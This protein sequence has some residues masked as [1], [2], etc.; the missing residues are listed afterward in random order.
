MMG[1][2]WDR[3]PPREEFRIGQAERLAE[4]FRIAAARGRPR[5]LEWVSYA[6]VGEVVW[7]KAG[8]SWLAL[9]PLVVRFESVPGGAMEDV[10]QAREPRAIVA[11]FRQV[12]RGWIP[13]A[14]AFFNLTP[15]QL[16]ER[17]GGS[18]VPAAP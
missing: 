17:S 16:I 11:V 3:K 7:A 2:L 10:P 12:G 1:W 13:D 18:W 14:R 8:G 9:V 4:W 6:E 15:T 5:G